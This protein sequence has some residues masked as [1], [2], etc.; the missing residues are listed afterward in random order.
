MVTSVS[1][2]ATIIDDNTGIKTQ[3]PI[4]LTEEGELSIV[5]EYLL[6]RRAEGA[7]DSTL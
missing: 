5:T 7:S 3:L 4:V 1:V 2:R 6:K